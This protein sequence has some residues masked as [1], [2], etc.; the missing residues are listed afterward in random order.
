VSTSGQG[1]VVGGDGAGIGGLTV[2]LEDVSTLF[3]RSLARGETT[4]TG[5]F[6][7]TYEDDFSETGSRELRLRI[8][9]GQHVVRED[10][11]PDVSSAQ[12]SYG[13]IQLPGTEGTSVLATLAT[14]APS[15][16]SQG[17]ALEWLC[18]DVD[19]WKRVADLIR[20]AGS[21]LDVMQLTI[22]MEKF[23]AAASDERPKIVLDFHDP[24]PSAAQPRKADANDGRIERLLLAASQKPGVIVRIQ[25][26]V[27]TVDLHVLPFAGLAGVIVGLALL[28]L[29]AGL[30]VG[31]VIIAAAII[32]LDRHFGRGV[33][34][35]ADWF[36]KAHADTKVRVR[37]LHTELFS[38]T[39]TKLVI[40]GERKAILLGSPFEQVYYDSQAHVLDEPRRGDD[41]GV[42]PIH[43]VSVSVRGPAVGHMQEVFNSHWNLADPTDPLPLPPPNIPQVTTAEKGELLTSVQVVRTLNPR[44]FANVPPNEKD[45]EKGILEAYLR[46]IHFAQRFIYLENQYFNDEAVTDAL[47]DV[48]KN[49]P[50]VKVIL[51]LNV[52]PDMPHYP[53]WQRTT[54]IRLADAAGTDVANRL[55][56]FTKWSHAASSPPTHPKPRLAKHYLHTKTAIIDNKWATV[57]SGNIDGA[58][59]DEFQAFWYSRLANVVLEGG[60]SRNTETNCVVFEETPPAKSA[61]DDLRRRLWAEHLGVVDAGGKIKPDAAE[62]NDSPTKDWLA[63]WAAKAEA[64]K[65]K[66]ISTPNDPSPIH[67]LP[68]PPPKKVGKANSKSHLELLGIPVEPFDL[69]PQGAPSFD[70][71]TGAFKK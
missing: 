57:G 69:V 32:K 45:G 48:L 43:D 2:V 28:S 7:L 34:V 30:I 71:K 41:A 56:V 47:I 6:S 20:N 67:I 12:L 5:A 40:D 65:A 49:K 37:A 62:L 13:Q 19:A 63:V 4:S 10:K 53:M 9:V 36:A 33:G 21:H 8:R 3:D 46:A 24:E 1:T 16:F 50:N 51:L 64:K 17:N 39:H 68:W 22:S 70:F 55:G 27:P 11:R 38:I 14:G 29:V 35:V 60:A 66:L 15:R 52:R 44:T 25:I 26:P 59:L 42:G 61:V 31:L 23:H 18:D 58:S 54:I